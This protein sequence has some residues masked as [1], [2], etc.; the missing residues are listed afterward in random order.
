[1]MMIHG[2]QWQLRWIVLDADDD[3]TDGLNGFSAGGV[4]RDARLTSFESEIA[5]DIGVPFAL[6]EVK[7]VDLRPRDPDPEV[8]AVYANFALNTA[9]AKK[10]WEFAARSEDEAREWAA[11]LNGVLFKQSSKASRVVKV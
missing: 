6:E 11:A 4:P 3:S 10:S 7:A 9:N 1:M 8:E 2:V 5:E